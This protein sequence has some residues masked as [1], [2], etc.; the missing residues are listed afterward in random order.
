LREGVPIVGNAA[1]GVEQ[2]KPVR[3]HLVRDNHVWRGV[4]RGDPANDEPGAKHPEQNA[5]LP[6]QAAQAALYLNE[7]YVIHVFPLGLDPAAG[8]GAFGTPYAANAPTV[9]KA[10]FNALSCVSRV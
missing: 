7:R 10:Y 9:A 2:G 1:R 6:L 3:A 5:V 8:N 4:R